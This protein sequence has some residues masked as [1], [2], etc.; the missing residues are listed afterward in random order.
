MYTN[1]NATRLCFARLKEREKKTKKEGGGNG[2]RLYH[3][4]TKAANAANKATAA[5]DVVLLNDGGAAP[6]NVT[7][8][9]VGGLGLP[10]PTGPGVPVTKPVPVGRGNPVLGKAPV[11]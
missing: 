1:A 10:D 7:G 11:E 8:D 4:R 9:W 3:I 5:P 2:I 6:A